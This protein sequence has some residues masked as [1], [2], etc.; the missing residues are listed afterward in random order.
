MP[1]SSLIIPPIYA[2]NLS[3]ISLNIRGILFFVLKTKC[4]LKNVNVPAITIPQFLPPRWGYVFGISHIR[5]LH[6]RLYAFCPLGILL[7]P[8]ANGDRLPTGV[9]SCH[10]FISTD[11]SLPFNLTACIAR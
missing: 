10:D 9:L 4:V 2:H 1:P 11:L 8:S 5:G 6:P 7:S 3:L